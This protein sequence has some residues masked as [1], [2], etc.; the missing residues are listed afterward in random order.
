MGSIR[1]K[2]YSIRYLIFVTKQRSPALLLPLY[3]VLRL[4]IIYIY[5]YIKEVRYFIRKPKFLKK[6]II[7]FENINVR[8]NCWLLKKVDYFHV[9]HFPV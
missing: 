6:L 4:Y 1:V 8:S 7:F 9:R 2:L 5:M 3:V